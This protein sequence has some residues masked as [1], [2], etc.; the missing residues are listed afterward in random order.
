MNDGTNGTTKPDAA[1][2]HILAAVRG[3]LASDGDSAEERAERVAIH[4]A[5]RAAP[6]RPPVGDDPV[7]RFLEKVEL[8]DATTAQVPEPGEVSRAVARYL[9]ELG[10]EKRI[11]ATTDPLTDSV[12]WSNEFAVERGRAAEADDRV[13][14]TG[15]WAAIAETGTLVLLSERATPTTLNFLPETH[16][17]L[18]RRDRIVPHIEDIW[19]ML[20]AER[21]ALPRTVNFITG[22]S[23]TGDIELQLELGAHG[24]RRLHIILVDAP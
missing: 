22:P 14:V 2:E 19:T 9:D 17:A 13:S 18:L 15:A 12:R 11:V 8:V 24:P 20:R 6:I 5:R 10:L 1:R 3:A 16:I 21:A 23:R 4:L 7:A